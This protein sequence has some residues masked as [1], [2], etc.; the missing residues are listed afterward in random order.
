MD[1][2]KLKNLFYDKNLPQ[3]ITELLCRARFDHLCQRREPESRKAKHYSGM[4]TSLQTHSSVLKTEYFIAFH[5]QE[6]KGEV[7]V[8][9]AHGVEKNVVL[10]LAKN[11]IK[12]DTRIEID[13]EKQ[14]LYQINA[15]SLGAFLLDESRS[16][17]KLKEHIDQTAEALA[18]AILHLAPSLPE[19]F[20]ELIQKLNWIQASKWCP[21][22][23][24]TVLFFTPEDLKAFCSYLFLGETQL[25]Q[26]FAKNWN[27]TFEVFLSAKY[28]F[29][30]RSLHQQ[31]PDNIELQRSL[32]RKI[33]YSGDTPFVESKLQDFFGTKEHPKI[34]GGKIPLKIILRGPHQRPIQITSDLPG[35]W[36][37]SY[38]EIKKELKGQYPKHFWPEDPANEL[39]P[40]KV[41]RG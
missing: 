39:P 30:L 8:R 20:K 5:A 1:A 32:H 37:S 36:K 3:K 31:F 41:R 35:F 21:E 23:F 6:L 33:E 28:S 7:V 12:T 25:S 2:F 26:V 10:R 38:A 17:G 24:A 40:L 9:S 14:N 19:H 29:D 4:G 11:Q 27:E 22:D 34:A 16:P 15:R 13:F 18:Y